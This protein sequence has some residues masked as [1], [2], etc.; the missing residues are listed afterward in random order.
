MAH[1]KTSE[2][3]GIIGQNYEH[4]KTKQRGVLESREEDYKNLIMRGPD[5]KSFN[6]SY[7]TFHSS[8]RK[9]QGDDVIKTSTQVEEE[10]AEQ[11]K[12]AKR[13]EKVVTEELTTTK[14]STSQKTERLDA[15]CDR[16]KAKVSDIDGI[17]VHRSIKGSVDITLGRF[18]LLEI[19]D[20]VKLEKYSFRLK[21]VVDNHVSTKFESETLD[22]D[23]MNI[24]YRVSGDDFDAILDQI[25][26]G[27]KAYIEAKKADKEEK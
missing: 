17:D 7:S 1:E 23:I 24:R 27:I 25:I 13:A 6:V 20:V 18:K 21:D 2:T 10:K 8:W 14:L 16:V 26:S 5:G 22:K 12:K 11:K 3:V 19:W 4:R 15:I 9:Y